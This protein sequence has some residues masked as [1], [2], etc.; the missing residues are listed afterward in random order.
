MA[1]KEVAEALDGGGIRDAGG[2]G[3]DAP[4]R[5]VDRDVV[6]DLLNRLISKREP[7]LQE[8]VPQQ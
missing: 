2:A 7:L 8:V 4:K 3:V 5:P 6:Q 1:L